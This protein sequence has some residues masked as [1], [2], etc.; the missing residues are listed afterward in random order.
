MEFKEIVE[1]LQLK[2]DEFINKISNDI[3]ADDAEGVA[4]EDV[5]S[6][7]LSIIEGKEV[8]LVSSEIWLEIA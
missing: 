3:K 5:I 4:V 6:V 7:K 1:L 2:H 8:V